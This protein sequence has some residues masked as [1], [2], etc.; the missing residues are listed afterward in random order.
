MRLR[1]GER[2]TPAAGSPPIELD[3]REV[4]EGRPRFAWCA[5]LGE[6]IRAAARELLAAARPP[7]EAERAAPRRRRR[8]ARRGR[9]PP[10]RAV[11][12]DSDAA[13]SGRWYAAGDVNAFFGLALDNL[14]NLVI[15]AGLL[16]GVFGF[17]ADLV[18]YRMVPGTA[19]GVLVGDLGYTWL[20]VRLARQTGRADVT[21]MPFGIDTPSLFGMTFGVLGPAMLAT[22][23]PVLA[24]KVGHGR[25]R[26]HG[27]RQARPGVRRRVGAA[28][29]AAR[30]RCSARSRAW[31][32]C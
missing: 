26:G 7:A 8:P 6:R 1:L 12:T 15:L 4:A 32:S 30:R 2:V 5:A 18:L 22:R 28:R 11:R 27:R 23:D 3:F 13:T 29:R 16:I 20:A 24:W 17:P 9:P 31:R 19:L 10:G 14:T 21:A 25:H